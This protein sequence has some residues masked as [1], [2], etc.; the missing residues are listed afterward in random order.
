MDTLQLLSKNLPLNFGK[1][2]FSPSYLQAGLIVFLLFVLILSLAQLR[3]HFIDWSIKG[4]LFGIFFGFLLAL[5]LE[6]FL[7]I[8]GKTAMIEVLGWENVPQPLAGVL[9]IGKE[10]LIQVLGIKDEI[11]PSVA[12]TT[13]NAIEVVRFFQSLVPA[14]AVKVK[15]I[16]CSP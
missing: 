11:P 15:K 6:G 2:S 10:R 1:M 12:K 4:A 13:P 7:I 3:R 16:I 14:E 5:V 8:G 9:D